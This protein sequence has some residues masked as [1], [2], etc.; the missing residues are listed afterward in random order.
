MI[1]VK[2]GIFQRRLEHFHGRVR[3]YLE[4]L[5]LSRSQGYVEPL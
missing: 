1:I 5:I 3:H 2:E 4:D